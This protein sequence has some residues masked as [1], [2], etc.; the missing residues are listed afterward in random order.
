MGGIRG[1]AANS[2]F[3]QQIRLDLLAIGSMHGLPAEA[4]SPPSGEPQALQPTGLG[5]VTGHGGLPTP[6][7]QMKKSQA[8]AQAQTPRQ[9]QARRQESPAA[10]AQPPRRARTRASVEVAPTVTPTRQSKQRLI[11]TL[12]RR[13]EGVAIG[14]L[15]TATGWQSHSVRAAL[16]GLRKRG[17]VLTR[18][19]GVDGQSA[20]RIVPDPAASKL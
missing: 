7:V 20:Y 13:E 4:A 3:S 19:A 16:T 10:A 17:R 8:K 1:R 11:E 12:L 18:H 9:A 14:E 6:E 2:G 15:M 5:V